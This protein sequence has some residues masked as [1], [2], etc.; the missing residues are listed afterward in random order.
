MAVRCAPPDNKPEP[1]EITRCL[2][3][4]D[5]EVAELPR[6]QVVVALGK[7]AFD[8]WLQS[9]ETEGRHASDHRG[10]SSDTECW[11]EWTRPTESPRSC[12]GA[13]TQAVRTRIPES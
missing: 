8:V 3:H 12:S 4:L 6:A 1:E 11:H 9:A 7:I 10:R 13:I 5:A 2:D